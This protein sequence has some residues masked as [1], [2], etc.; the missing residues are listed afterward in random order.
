MFNMTIQ[1][2]EATLIDDHDEKR[3]ISNETKVLQFLEGCKS[4]SPSD[5]GVLEPPRKKARTSSP[6]AG[7]IRNRRD[8]VVM[9]VSTID[10]LFDTSSDFFSTGIEKMAQDPNRREIPL[11]MKLDEE[12]VNTFNLTMT[13]MHTELSCTLKLHSGN[14]G[15][16]LEDSREL[17]QSKGV[18]KKS[19]SSTAT[20]GP[21][22]FAPNLT[23]P[24]PGNPSAFGIELKTLWHT[25][26]F[27]LDRQTR[28]NR[29]LQ[30]VMGKTFHQDI[31]QSSASWSPQRFYQNVHVPEKNAI[32]PASIQSDLMT[33]KLYPF[34]KR[35][36]TWM[37]YREGVSLADDGKIVKTNPR[38]SGLP[39]SFTE[40][41]DAEN[42]PCFVSHLFSVVTRDRHD[43]ESFSPRLQGGLLAEEMGQLIEESMR[44][45][46]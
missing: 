39:F 12:D 3:S 1:M 14:L 28:L 35:A 17:L 23:F 24:V 31:D 45:T 44:V 5:L 38:N 4:S 13:L 9:R 19:F 30:Q 29:H 43:L 10:V 20:I 11:S 46:S 16:L 15:S 2:F 25:E 27:S 22:F 18:A 8:S 21:I 32:P 41:K 42:R 34:Q 7:Q 26:K 33:C 36:A 40:E 6:S 37:L